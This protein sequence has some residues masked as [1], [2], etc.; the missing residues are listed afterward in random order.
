[1][2][3]K[4]HFVNHGNMVDFYGTGA[5]SQAEVAQKLMVEGKYSETLELEI[6]LPADEIADEVFD[7]SNN[8]ARQD[9]RSRVY[10]NGRSLS[11]GDVVEV[12]GEMLV[13]C[14]FGWGLMLD[15]A[16]LKGDS[17]AN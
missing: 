14:S 9:E 6:N 13:C 3:V 15:F 10:G 7:L 5:T 17:Y 1:M 4:I 2:K 12:D 8:P 11:V 16:K